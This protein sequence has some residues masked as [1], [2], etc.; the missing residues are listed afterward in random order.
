MD[1]TPVSLLQ[2]LRQRDADAWNEFVAVVTP[3]LF[4]VARRHGLRPDEAADLVQ[5]VL[6]VAV[7]TL[8][9]FRYDPSRSFRAWLATVLANKLR[10]QRARRRPVLLPPAELPEPPDPA[11]PFEEEEYRRWL[12]AQA[13]ER[14]E[15][16]ARPQDLAVCREYVM[17]DRP[18]PEVAPELGLEVHAVHVISGRLLARLREFL[19][20][21]L[22]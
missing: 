8:P 19:R 18:A 13:L 2:R 4:R 10:D 17:K 15:R 1:F 5:D 16:Q 7:R 6:L 22:E 11:E 20:G 9:T 12:A 21:M 14:L 3:F